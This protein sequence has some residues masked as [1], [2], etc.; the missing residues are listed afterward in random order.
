MKVSEKRFD[1]IVKRALAHIPEEIRKHLDNLVI[2]VLPRPSREMRKEMGLR[3]NDEVLGLFRGIALIERSV[4]SPP[5]YPD[6]IFLFQGPLEEMAETVE[7][8]E[9]QIEIT[10]VHEVA[11]YIG[12]D[13][14]RLAELGYG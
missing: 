13:E 7:E 5:L 12:M 1:G 14:E 2:S 9:E 8:L 4:T 3:P 10:V 6:T 11:H